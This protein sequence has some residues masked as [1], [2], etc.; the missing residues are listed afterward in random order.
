[1]EPK[2][3]VVVPVFKV[4]QYLE[5]CINSL[6]HQTYKNLEI[7]LVDDGSPD[8]CGE[9]IE[10][11]AKKDN[12]VVA[13][14]Q[15][16]AGLSA[17][18]NTGMR[19][20]TGVWTVF[21]DS[22]DW[23]AHRMI[24]RLVRT[25]ERFGADVVQAAF[26]YA[27]DDYLLYDHRYFAQDDA[28]TVLKKKQLMAALVEN[29]KVKNF[30]WGKLYKTAL[31][32][33]IPFKK[34][35]IFEDVFWAHLVMHKANTYVLVHEPLYYYYQRTDSIVATYTTRNLDM[36][37]GLKERHAFIEAHYKE[38]IATSHKVILRSCFIHYHL[39]AKNKQ[40]DR[41]GLYRRYIRL[42][43]K[44]NDRQLLRAVRDDRLLRRQMR[45]FKLHPYLYLTGD[46][47]ERVLRKIGIMTRPEA[48]KRV[49]LQEE[50]A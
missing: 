16:N 35:V 21:V 50:G 47:I 5:R 28:P 19:H 38:L 31:I 39:L 40:K 33:D 34:G 43:I 37:R 13:V 2:V 20:A 11:Y 18:R 46:L 23:L 49:D 48:L 22:D 17:A 12:R 1:M 29:E 41:G 7:I 15:K 8:R 10:A 26:Y 30:A 9:M 14:H 25:G 36:L 32:K 45:L 42:Y 6:L 27:Y 44:Q 3:S 4:E 24:E